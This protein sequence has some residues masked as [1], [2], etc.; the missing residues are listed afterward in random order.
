MTKDTDEK[1]NLLKALDSV[2]A[3]IKSM[4]L[5]ELQAQLKE[6]EGTVFA[7]TINELISWNHDEN[8]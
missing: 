2:V 1:S 3:E 5:G 6:S 8:L 4:P 7:K